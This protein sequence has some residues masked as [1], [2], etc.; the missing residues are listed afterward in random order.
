[1]YQKPFYELLAGYEKCRKISV[2]PEFFCRRAGQT[3]DIYTVK[4]G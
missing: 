2:Q 3:G 1:V 4:K